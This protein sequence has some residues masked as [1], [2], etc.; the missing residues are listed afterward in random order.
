MEDDEFEI[1][2]QVG[3]DNFW[4]DCRMENISSS[5]GVTFGAATTHNVISRT[6]ISSQTGREEVQTPLGTLLTDN[7]FNNSVR[8]A[9]EEVSN[10]HTVL[11]ISPKLLIVSD[12][13]A[14]DDTSSTNRRGILDNEQWQST[15]QNQRPVVPCRETIVV[16]SNYARLGETGLIPVHKGSVFSIAGHIDAGYWRF[17]I[18]VFDSDGIPLSDSAAL[19]SNNASYVSAGLYSSS[20]LNTMT[21]GSHNPYGFNVTTDDA[22]YVNITVGTGSALNNIIR[23]ITCVYHEPPEGYLQSVASTELAS[24]DLYLASAPTMGYA[25][26][27]T[28]VG[29]SSGDYTCTFELSTVLTAQEA[30]G[31]TSITVDDITNTT[32]SGNIANGDVVGIALDDGTT[33]WSTVSG[34][35]GNTFTVDALA[36][37]AGTAGAK[38]L[39]GAHVVFVRWAT[40]T[41]AT[42]DLYLSSAPNLHVG[43]ESDANITSGVENVIL[44]TELSGANLTTGFGNTIAGANTAK[45]LATGNNN[46]IIGRKAMETIG[47]PDSCVAI[48]AFAAPNLNGDQNTVVGA[49]SAQ[50]L[51][52]GQNNTIIGRS[53]GD[54]ITTGNGNTCIG[55]LSNTGSA[56]AVNRIAIGTNVGG[57]NDDQFSFGKF[58]SIVSNDFGTDAL[59]SRASD[60]R[61]KENIED[62]ELGLDLI[63]KLRPVD[64]NWKEGW[65]NQD[66]KITGLIAQEVEAALDGREFNGHKVQSDGYQELKMEAFIPVLINAVKELTARVKE[67]EGK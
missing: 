61:K 39:L 52:S 18:Q 45:N 47:N 9:Q 40:S 3:H 26:L 25:A 50:L 67:L 44:S 7:G 11:N 13:V 19:E 1:D 65:G 43:A 10:T 46:T 35:S 53:A 49:S 2:L 54:D 48:G 41:A 56:S 27:G 37:P 29:T 24:K 12:G 64:F 38:G 8:R 5:Q 4:H 22:A 42:T 59:W 33:H 28:K 30:N 6:W 16:P 15:F 34:L 51:S 55:Y 23:N 14:Y 58:G 63:C 31:S 66:V 62:S 60:V 57:T 20:D 32:P 21:L 17:E 36:S